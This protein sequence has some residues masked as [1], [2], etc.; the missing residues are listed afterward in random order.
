MIL[1]T[2]C[3]GKCESGKRMA[4]QPTTVEHHRYKWKNDGPRLNEEN[5]EADGFSGISAALAFLN[6]EPIALN[7]IVYQK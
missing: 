2:Y 3:I 1:A 4:R 6:F 7:N 5:P